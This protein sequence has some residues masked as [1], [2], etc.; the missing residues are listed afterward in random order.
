MALELSIDVCRA[1]NCRSFT[2]TEET[3][4]YNASTNTGGYGAPNIA[5]TDVLTATITV[6]PY[7]GDA[8][9][10]VSVY[11][12]L[13]SSTD[14]DITINNTDLGLSS[15]TNIPDNIYQILYTITGQIAVTAASVG[16][17]TFTVSGDR[18]GVFA[19]GDTFTITGGS[20]NN[21]TYT[22][23][24]SSYG[25]GNTVITVVEAPSSATITSNKINFTESTSQ[26]EVF[27]CTTEACITHKLNAL[28][29]GECADCLNNQSEL[30]KKID[31]FLECARKAAEC[32]KPA[33]A[34]VIL[35][36][37]NTLCNLQGCTDC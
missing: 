23:V 6:T 19:A 36:Y 37:V 1:S 11:S 27:S 31:V 4:A 35:N 5:T 15:T 9:P 29:V 25:G 2:V 21:G 24:G 26:Y 30:I 17:K 22:V 10:T 7:N 14:G 8:Y 18:S 16:S 13:P 32:S 3:G 28:N 20:T 12:T 34:Q 33:K